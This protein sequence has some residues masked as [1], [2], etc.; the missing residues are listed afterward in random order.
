MRSLLILLKLRDMTAECKG[1][2]GHCVK[3]DSYDGLNYCT[4]D[5]VNIIINQKLFN[6][7]LCMNLL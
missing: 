2:L 1:V 6:A 7:P 4:S 3:N 5:Q